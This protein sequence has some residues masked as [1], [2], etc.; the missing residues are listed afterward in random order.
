MP[1]LRLD[2][3]TALPSWQ[4]TLTA[5]G[6]R[7]P[8]PVGRHLAAM[9]RPPGWVRSRTHGRPSAA[10]YAVGTEQETL[11]DAA[12]RERANPLFYDGSAFDR[13][14][15]A[16]LA[17][18][19]ELGRAGYFEPGNL[20]WTRHGDVSSEPVPDGSWLVCTC[21]PAQGCH[22]QWLAPFLARAGW[23]VRLYGHP[24]DP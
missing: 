1:I 15:S 7:E 12:L 14:R 5:F 8:I 21:K 18:F 9:A 23:D 4:E 6:L 16:M 11:L 2:T 10:C 22:L 17:K 20:R 3:A 13:Y 24:V 19:E